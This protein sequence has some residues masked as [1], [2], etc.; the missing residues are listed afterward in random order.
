MV[1]KVT[2]DDMLSASRLPALMGLS[3]YRS[4]NDELQYSIGAMQGEVVRTEGNE[5]MAWGNELEPVILRE[6]ARRLRLIDLVTEHPEA[7][8]HPDVPLCCSLDGTA[9][10]GGQIITTDPD[11]GIFVVGQ[12]QIE[13]AG[14]GVLEAKLTSVS[15]EDTPALYRGP[16][17]LQ[18]QMDIVQ[19]RWGCIAVLYQGTELRLFLFA[20]H[21]ALVDRIYGLATD[22]QRRLDTWKRSQTIDW[23]PPMSSKDAD[24]MFPQADEAA[25]DLGSE[26]ERLARQ[27]IDAKKTISQAE[28][29]REEAEKALKTMLRTA[30]RGT[31]GNIEIKW[32]MRNYAATPQKIVPP[33]AAYSVRQSTLSVKELRP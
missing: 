7:K 24:R 9:D 25:I 21:A 16:I 32:P 20:P 18:A 5:A 11:Q 15:P 27:I 14:T 29:E 8:F 28:A 10:G 19:A 4:P 2:P 6:A 17:Q 22:F 3:K 13:L 30:S 31:A 12:D 23:Y 26:G 1:S 33:K